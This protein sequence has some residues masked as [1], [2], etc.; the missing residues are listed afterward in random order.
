MTYEGTVQI[1]AHLDQMFVKLDMPD[2]VCGKCI[3][4]MRN[5]GMEFK[6]PNCSIIYP[7]KERA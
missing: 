2:L 3:C 7:E 5:T 4:E 6:C 1:D